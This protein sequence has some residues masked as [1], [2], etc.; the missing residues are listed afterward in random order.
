MAVRTEGVI[1]VDVA[2]Q[3]K[4]AVQRLTE[5]ADHVVIEE[6]GEAVAVVV[7]VESYRRFK[8][9]E[10]AV[11]QRLHDVSVQISQAF[12]DVPDD[13]LERELEKARVEYR[14]AE[15]QAERDAAAGRFVPFSTPM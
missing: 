2:S 7:P 15:K 13:E 3:V 6:R 11:R 12:A 8:R 5:G 4:V 9:Q 10:E 1:E 14:A